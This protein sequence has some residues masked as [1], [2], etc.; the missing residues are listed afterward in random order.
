MKLTL[1]PAFDPD[2][3]LSI[4]EGDRDLF[5]ELV[6]VFR[7]NYPTELSSIGDAISRR[8]AEGLRRASHHFKGTVCALAAGPACDAAARLE[9]IGRSEDLTKAAA[10][11][12]E[13]E[14]HIQ[15]LDAALSD[16]IK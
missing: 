4:V 10:T 11:F 2:E 5:L 8:D 16:W 7:E 12:A 6:N 1:N 13:M 15:A 14:Q 9:E 3:A